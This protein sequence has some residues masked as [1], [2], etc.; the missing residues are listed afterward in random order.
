M[1]CYDSLE[2]FHV[3]NLLYKCHNFKS[4]FNHHLDSSDLYSAALCSSRYEIFWKKENLRVCWDSEKIYLVHSWQLRFQ[5][6][7]YNRTQKRRSLWLLKKRM[8]ENRS[9]WATYDE[10][11]QELQ[12]TKL[13]LL[14]SALSKFSSLIWRDEL[15]LMLLN[16]DT[17]LSWAMTRYRQK[18]EARQTFETLMKSILIKLDVSV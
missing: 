2:S 8:R 16:V 3:D 12:V 6:I 13:R 7:L 17:T 4:E 18:N 10:I 9:W 15:L 11:S 5:N 1:N 14:T